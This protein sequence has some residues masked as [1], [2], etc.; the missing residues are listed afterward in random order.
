MQMYAFVCMYVRVCSNNVWTQQHVS[1]F[2]RILVGVSESIKRQLHCL[3]GR[4]PQGH[5]PAGWN[6]GFAW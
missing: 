3:V 4:K 6:S 2:V 1:K 5:V